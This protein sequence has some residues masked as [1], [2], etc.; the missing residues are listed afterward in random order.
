MYKSQQLQEKQLAERVQLTA[1]EVEA[2]LKSTAVVEV[3]Q[4]T[5]NDT[6]MIEVGDCWHKRQCDVMSG[7]TVSVGV[8]YREGRRSVNGARGRRS[9][10][11]A[12]TCLSSTPFWCVL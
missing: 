11:R 4:K 6:L 1:A 8:L 3:E 9:G 7:L 5:V 10:R 12:C 2:K